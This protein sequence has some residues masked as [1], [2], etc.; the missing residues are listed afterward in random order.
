MNYLVSDVYAYMY[1]YKYEYKCLSSKEIYDTNLPVLPPI[2][3]YEY[4][5]HF[6]DVFFSMSNMFQ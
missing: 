3:D 1:I 2:T 4:Q 5:F 6:H